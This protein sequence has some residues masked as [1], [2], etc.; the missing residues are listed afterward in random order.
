M[1]FIKR[2]ADA[3]KKFESV[4]EIASV[5]WIERI[6]IVVEG[7]LAAETDIE[8]LAVSKIADITN[9]I[10]GDRKDL[11]FIGQI[12]HQFV[13]GFFHAFPARINRVAFALVIGFDQE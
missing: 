13:R 5:K 7:E 3:Q 2:R 12:Y 9:S 1:S 10:T 8:A 11:R 6:W 4:T